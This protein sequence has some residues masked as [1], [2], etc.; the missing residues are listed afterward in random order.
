MYLDLDTS[1]FFTLAEQPRP[2]KTVKTTCG[3]LR[4]VAAGNVLAWYGVPYARP[5]VGDL[6]WKPPLAPV[7]WRGVRDAVH[8]GDQAAQD[9]A[10]KVYGMG[11][12]S[13]DCLNLNILAPKDAKGLPVM[14]WL[15]GGAFMMLTSNMQSYN[16]PA[17]LP[18]KGVVL[19]T[20]NH[21]LGP[22][23]YMAHPLLSKES[24]YGGSGNYGQMDLIAALQWVRDNIAAFGGDPGNV[25]IFGQS[26]GGAKVIS[27]MASPLAKG[28][29]NRAICQ[30][31]MVESRNPFMNTVDLA[32]AEARGASLS[33]RLSAKTLAELRAVPWETI[34]ASDI[35][36]YA[37]NIAAYGPNI[38]GYYAQHTTLDAIRAGIVN[39]VPLMAGASATD[40]VS[41][42]DLVPGLL[43]QM[44]LR[45]VHC[46]AP[47]YVYCFTHLPAGWRAMGAKAY[48]GTELAYLFNFPASFV[49]HFLL[50]LTALSPHQIGD[51]DGN[52]TVADATDIYLSTRYGAED[53]AMVDA[54]MTLWTSFAKTGHPCIPGAIEWQPYTQATERFLEIATPLAMKTGL[55]K[56][57]GR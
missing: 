44:P 53:V 30:S 18:A 41:D 42:G 27:L 49:A 13:E 20:V 2:G 34:I 31:G 9:V 11:G 45:A 26:G 23:G 8:Y 43:E 19:V 57:F 56:G 48:H 47:Q 3:D 25:T 35:A 54:V 50:G 1:K 5:P 51:Q 15:H 46:K 4:G 39:D 6:R 33:Q 17:A 52:G 28:L 55:A 14:V 36:H 40:L 29:F 21:R 22:F 10:Y 7:A 12:M 37:A 24:G 32:A 16:N 38:D